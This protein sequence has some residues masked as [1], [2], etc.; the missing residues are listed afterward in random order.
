MALGKILSR[1]RVTLPRAIRQAAGLQPGDVLDF[2][3]IAP[4]RLEV[5]VL[6]RLRLSEALERYRIEGPVDEAADRAEWQAK[7]A[8]D[9]LGTKSE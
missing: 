3:V 6:P 9:I 1:G 2:K 4:G 7:A 5:R 8:E